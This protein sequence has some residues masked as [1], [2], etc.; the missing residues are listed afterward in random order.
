MRQGTRAAPTHVQMIIAN[1]YA[2][3]VLYSARHVYTVY[4]I[5]VYS[6]Y[7][8]R[9]YSGGAREHF[10]FTRK[11]DFR[12]VPPTHTQNDAG[13][14]TGC[15]VFAPDTRGVR[16]SRADS[17]ALRRHAVTRTLNTLCV[18][19]FFVPSAR[20]I[21]LQPIGS[22]FQCCVVDKFNLLSVRCV[23]VSFISKT[24]ALART[25][26]SS[27]ARA[28]ILYEMM[29]GDMYYVCVC[30]QT[31]LYADEQCHNNSVCVCMWCDGEAR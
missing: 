7:P 21:Y 3:P 4:N 22:F 18:A 26:H 28:E 9:R 16:V 17:Q 12:I 13:G 29:M 19:L 15:G 2:R 5:H 14:C 31:S 6:M 11:T 20:R 30:A 24:L 8:R 1:T 25:Q 10:Q 23:A 27:Y